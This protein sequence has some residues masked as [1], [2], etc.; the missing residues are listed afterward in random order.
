MS[1]IQIQEDIR[2]IKDLLDDIENSLEE[3]LNQ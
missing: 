1:I 3:E 2:R